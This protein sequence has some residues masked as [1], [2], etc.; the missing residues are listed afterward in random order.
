MDPILA[1][2]FKRTPRRK[3]SLLPTYGDPT[4]P[5]T[6]EEYRAAIERMYQE[7]AEQIARDLGLNPTQFK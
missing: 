1:R 4:N 5:M 6:E 7:E 3:V 2:R